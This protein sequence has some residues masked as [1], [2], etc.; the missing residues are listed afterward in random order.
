MNNIFFLS[1]FHSFFSYF[2]EI[3]QALNLAHTSQSLSFV[4]H[5]LKMFF[6]FEVYGFLLVSFALKFLIFS[7]GSHTKLSFVMRDL[8]VL[9]IS[10]ALKL[11]HTSQSSLIC[12]VSLGKALLLSSF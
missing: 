4:A 11:T 6:C 7:L 8:S 9:L 2:S 1:F 3:S 12:R 5:L 10:F